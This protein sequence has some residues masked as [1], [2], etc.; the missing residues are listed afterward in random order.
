MANSKLKEG[1]TIDEIVGFL[2]NAKKRISKIVYGQEKVKDLI[3]ISILSNGHSIITGVPGLAKTMLIKHFSKLFKLSFSRI[4][5]TPDMMPSDI[6]GAEIIDFDENKKKHFTFHKGPVFANLILA[7][8]INRT[9]PKTQAALLQ[10]MEEKTITVAGIAYELQR[11]FFVFAT[12]NPIEQEGTYPLPEAELD[13]FL[14][15]IEMDY[16]KNDI[17]ID[18]SANYPDIENIELESIIDGNKLVKYIDFIKN[19]EISKELIEKIVELIRNTRPNTTKFD[20]IKNYLKWGAGPR[21]S[22]YLMHASKAMALLKG[23][24][25]VSDEDVKNLIYPII[26]HRIILSFSANA[27]NINKE[28]I[29]DR[30]LKELRWQ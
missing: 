19:I 4:Q 17:E 10:A 26:K 13:R 14:F 30:L 6:I 11:P 15:N 8:E 25:I 28:E 3:L 2:N 23:H 9:P 21:A 16:P 1:K 27:E 20:F 7:D 18:I 12:Q 5:F 29:L 24:S 22:Q